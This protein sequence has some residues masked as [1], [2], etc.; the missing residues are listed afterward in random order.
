[1]FGRTAANRTVPPLIGQSPPHAPCGEGQR[2]TGKDGR[3]KFL[4]GKQL[5]EHITD[6]AGVINEEH[7]LHIAANANA[8]RHARKP[9]EWL[10]EA[11]RRKGYRSNW[12]RWSE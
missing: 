6:L 1:M 5:A 10:V 8:L 9:G 12:G 4:T 7:G 3:T 11:K 2:G